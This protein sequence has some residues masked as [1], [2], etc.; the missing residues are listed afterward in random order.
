[1][2]DADGPQLRLARRRE[3][4][5]E[6]VGRLAKAFE[7]AGGEHRDLAGF[8]SLEGVAGHFEDPDGYAGPPP[9][10]GKA[11]GSQAQIG[12]RMISS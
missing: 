4:F 2:V 7:H 11:H 1:M 12:I 10:G 9:G 5:G 8:Q 3:K 6:R